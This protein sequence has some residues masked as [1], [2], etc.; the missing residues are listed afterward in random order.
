MSGSDKPAS[1]NISN[2]PGE[3]TSSKKPSSRSVRGSASS[4]K[5]TKTTVAEE[6]YETQ[7]QSVKQLQKL[8][9]TLLF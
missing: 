1:G 7:I 6:A 2:V 9:P 4:A 8:N 5:K 3:N